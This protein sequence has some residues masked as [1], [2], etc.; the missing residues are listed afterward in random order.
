MPL[1]TVLLGA[2]QAIALTILSVELMALYAGI[3]RFPEIY[4]LMMFSWSVVIFHRLQR[5]DRERKC[6]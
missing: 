3:P 5:I 6:Q 4:A 1:T 2:A